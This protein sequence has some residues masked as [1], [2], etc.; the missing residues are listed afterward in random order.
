M[1]QASLPGVGTG[2]HTVQLAF[3]GN[4]ITASYDGVPMVSVTDQDPV[5]YASG[6]VSLDMGTYLIP[7]TML[8]SQ[9][10][11]Q[12]LAGGQTTSSSS[13]SSSSV[14]LAD[15][16]AGAT[17][18]GAL[19]PWS[20]QTGVWNI[21]GGMMVGGPDLEESYGF[22]ILNTNWND[23]A[24]QA[25]LQFSSADAVGGG[26]GAYLDTAT[27]AHYAAWVYPEGSPAGSSVIKLLKF[28]D[29]SS[30]SYQGVGSAPMAQ[31]NLPGVGTDW[32]TVQLAIQGNQITVTYD[33]VPMINT[34][35]LEPAPYV[36][37]GVS[38]D[39]GTY[40]APTTMA[41]SQVAVTSLAGAALAAQ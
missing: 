8:V 4:Q 41:V 30:Y 5:P 13:A 31:A 23:Y 35:D 25:R 12:P 15:D 26:V 36:G 9:V 21:T 2:W 1:G 3:Q 33:G 38:L 16:F 27:G 18:P 17:N 11:V 32:H 22:A 37:G 10:T 24:V 7:T 28:Q 34:T 14:L 39:M 6:G 29:W 19:S 40:L 20:A